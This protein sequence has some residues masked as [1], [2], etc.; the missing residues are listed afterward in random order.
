MKLALIK[1]CPTIAWHNLW[2]FEVH[3]KKN[4]AAYSKKYIEIFYPKLY[5]YV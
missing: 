1:A 5:V 2:E 4:S 3:V